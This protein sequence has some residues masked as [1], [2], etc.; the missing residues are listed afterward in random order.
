HRR[1]LR[2][3]AQAR[4][5]SAH[6]STQGGAVRPEDA[7][8]LR[9]RRLVRGVNRPPL[10]ACPLERRMEPPMNADERGW[11]YL[12]APSL[13]GFAAKAQRRQGAKKGGDFDSVS[14]FAPSRL[15]AFALKSK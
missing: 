3:S 2:S 10:V 14:S 15:C 4:T 5:A 7:R 11:F 6:R 9:A 12:P 1:P 13:A 8:P